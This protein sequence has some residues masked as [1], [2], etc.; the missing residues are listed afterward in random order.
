MKFFLAPVLLAFAT[1]GV[2]AEIAKPMQILNLSCMEALVTIGQ[3][4]LAG[5]F[6]FVPE[7]DS[8]AALAD[9]LV[10]DKSALKKFL[11]KAEK[12]YKLVTGVSVWDHDV[13][14]FA[15]SIYN[16]SLAQ[17]L[18]KPGGKIIARINKL[19]AAPTRTL[20]EKTARR[21]K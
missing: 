7:R 12:D 9:L 14:Q 21:Q 6:S 2:L 11:A 3:A 19:A 18:P 10:H 8:H 1:A 20:Q 15:L 17:T 16:S 4:D 5:V 13:L